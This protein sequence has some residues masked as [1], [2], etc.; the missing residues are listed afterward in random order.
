MTDTTS[1]KKDVR[2]QQPKLPFLQIYLRGLQ[3]SDGS[4]ARD[5][6]V[7]Y[8]LLLLLMLDCGVRC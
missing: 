1:E 6:Y 8:G 7:G 2:K 3:R 4:V 5:Q